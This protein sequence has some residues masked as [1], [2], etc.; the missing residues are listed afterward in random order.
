MKNVGMRAIIGCLALALAAALVGAGEGPPFKR[1]RDVIYGRSFGTA[2]T[3]DVFTPTAKAN[4]AAVIHVISGGWFSSP[5]GI[6]PKTAAAFTSRGYAV[7]SVVHGSQPKYA[8]NEIL[9]DMH[10][11]VRFIRTSA[12]KFGI[13][14]ERIAITGA[15]AGGHLSLMQG[16]A[17][18]RG[19]PKAKDPIDRASSRVQAVACFVPPT[20]FLNF[21]ETGRSAL[22]SLPD[23]I[24]PA[25]DF[26][27]REPKTGGFVRV[28]DPRRVE[29][30]LRDVSPVTHVSK[31]SA[32]ALIIH[33]EKDPLVPL[34]QAE[35]MVAKLKEAGVPAELVVKAGQGHVWADMDKD[36]PKMADWFDKHLA[37]KAA[38]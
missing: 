34:Q 18:T 14:P 32:P 23:A 35:V 29:A 36:L 16:T 21:G 31:E 5:E 13:D 11:A 25:F 27:E 8:I 37:K 15:S 38:P 26:R 4:G 2:L 3:M 20:D 12:A 9:L 10:R 24:K 17:G 28:A 19:N 7:F 30:I 6:N 22:T 1:Q 33:G